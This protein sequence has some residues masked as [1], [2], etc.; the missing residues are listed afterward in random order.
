M[1]PLVRM[2]SSRVPA[3]LHTCLRQSTVRGSDDHS[4]RRA[5]SRR[6]RASARPR[7]TAAS[8][9]RPTRSISPSLPPIRP[10]R[11]PDSSRRTSRRPRQ[12]SSRSV[13]SRGRGGVAR[14]IVVNSGCANACTGDQGMSRCR[15]HGHRGGCGARRAIRAGARGI[16]RRHRRQSQD[17]RVVTRH[18]AGAVAALARGK[19]SETA[20]AIMTTDPFPKEYAVTVQTGARDRSRSAA[21]RR[22]RA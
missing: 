14:A 7:F 11:R 21:R 10:P 4:H 18:S 17:G 8:R 15:A 2:Q 13:I 6:R 5:A 19:G 3:R 12:C 22:A 9:P 16:D 1:L 20:R